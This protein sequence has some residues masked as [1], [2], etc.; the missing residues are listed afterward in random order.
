MILNV[1]DT[2]YVRCRDAVRSRI[3]G[4]SMKAYVMTFGCQQ[5]EVD[6]ETIRGIL[7]DMGYTVSSDYSE[8]D[9]IILNT[10]AIREH[11]EAK[12][13]S[14]LGNFKPLKQQ[15]PWLIVGVVGCMAAES[16]VIVT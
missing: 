9:V 12:V 11:A 7:T 1:N 5:N 14:M 13:F 4:K 10:C 8:C 2:D 3:S 16:G 6:S 15:K